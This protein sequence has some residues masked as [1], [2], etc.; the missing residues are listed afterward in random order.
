MKVFV[1]TSNCVAVKR[2]C[3]S[4]AIPA[5]YG[6]PS[7][8]TLKVSVESNV[9]AAVPATLTTVMLEICSLEVAGSRPSEK[10]L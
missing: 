1:A 8:V 9:P 10:L 6:W 3:F 7:T 4:A 2:F 5:V